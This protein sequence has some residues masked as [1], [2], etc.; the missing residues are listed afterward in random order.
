MSRKFGSSRSASAKVDIHAC[1]CIPTVFTNRKSTKESL[2]IQCHN[3]PS[4][5]HMTVATMESFN[6]KKC[7]KNLLLLP[8]KTHKT[9][10]LK[11][12]EGTFHPFEFHLLH[13]F[14]VCVCVC[15]CVKQNIKWKQKESTE[16]RMN[17]GIFKNALKPITN[18]YTGWYTG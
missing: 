10:L 16:K 11:N 2:G 15:V 3:D 7:I 13:P 8:H 1:L 14:C 17:K 6:P 9:Q 4:H 5:S 12:P 18:K